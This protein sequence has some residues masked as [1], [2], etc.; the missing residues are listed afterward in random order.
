[1]DIHLFDVR[2][3]DISQ[4]GDLQA[5]MSTFV[6]KEGAALCY[7]FSMAIKGSIYRRAHG[8]SKN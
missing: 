4:D 8:E 7:S 1:M 6:S 3:W 2:I 5:V